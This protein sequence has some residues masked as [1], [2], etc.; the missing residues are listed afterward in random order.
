MSI[1]AARQVVSSWQRGAEF[2][3]A[4]RQLDKPGPSRAA[5]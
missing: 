5:H 2:V 3:R 1:D 4:V